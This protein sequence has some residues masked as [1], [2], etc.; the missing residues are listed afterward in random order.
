MSI[1]SFT[2]RPAQAADPVEA[3]WGLLARATIDPR[4]LALAIQAVLIEPK[5]DWR[6][7][8]LVK[9]GW[10]ALEQAVEPALLNEYLL[11]G[12]ACQITE[13]MQARMLDDSRGHQVVKFPSIKGR[14]MPHVSSIMV[15][16][17]LRELGSTIAPPVTITMGGAASLILRELLSR[18]TEDVGVVD[19]VP[20]EVRS[21]HEIL[22]G[23]SA[24]YGLHLTHFQ[25][26]YLPAGWESRTIDFGAFGGIH[27][28]LVDVVDITA[29]KVL[30]ARAKDLDDFRLLSLSLDKEELRHRVI[31]GSSCLISSEQSR[32][33][34][35]KNWYIVYGEDLGLDTGKGPSD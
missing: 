7:I 3:L 35:I 5:L 29:G 16:Q 6:T 18:A 20:V 17:F 12:K 33:Q 28:R 10:E 19:E 34:A 31:Q 22:E 9:E 24:R 11:S 2:D 13:A 14:L 4:A 25:S 21:Q 26:H 23:L 30:S 32:Q 27:V 15:R 8:Q 1:S